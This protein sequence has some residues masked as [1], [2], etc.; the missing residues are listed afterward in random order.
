[1]P[2]EIRVN[3]QLFNYLVK[4]CRE[5][6]APDPLDAA[7]DAIL[8]I[9]KDGIR[10]IK[11]AAAWAVGEQKRQRK[12]QGR[13]E[14]LDQDIEYTPPEPALDIEEVT[15]K[16]VSRLR[17]EELEMLMLKHVDGASMNE[18]ATTFGLAPG[19]LATHLHR[20]R[21]RV[22]SWVNEDG[23]SRQPHREAYDDSDQVPGKWGGQETVK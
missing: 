20:V 12:R 13:I 19:A 4:Q 9:L 6:G 18:I 1:M 15:K 17:P 3:G 16:V 23:S 21:A 5:L 10:G 14:A 2:D 22:R 7:Q 8:R 11:K